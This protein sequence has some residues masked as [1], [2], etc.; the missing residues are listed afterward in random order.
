MADRGACATVGEGISAYEADGSGG[1]DRCSVGRPPRRFRCRSSRGEAL[2]PDTART[3]CWSCR[4]IA[5]TFTGGGTATGPRCCSTVRSATGACGGRSLQ[6]SHA[7]T[8]RCMPRGPSWPWPVATGR[9]RDRRVDRRL[10]GRRRRHRRPPQPRPAPVQSR[11]GLLDGGHELGGGQVA[12][13]GAAVAG[14]GEGHDGVPEPRVEIP[15]A[16]ARGRAVAAREEQH[17]SPAPL[18]DDLDVT[19]GRLNG[20]GWGHRHILLQDRLLRPRRSRISRQLR[21]ER[22]RRRRAHT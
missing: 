12:N 4:A 14:P 15:A 6:P 19:Q 13:A 5:C 11:A 8:I 3:I 22:S 10:G 21:A 7:R 1:S 17:R 9:G 2:A 16:V 18:D 20:L